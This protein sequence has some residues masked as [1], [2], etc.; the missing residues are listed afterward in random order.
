L[1]HVDDS[2]WSLFCVRT[3]EYGRPFSALAR[4]DAGQFDVVAPING[5]DSNGAVVVEIPQC[6]GSDTVVRT[7]VSVIDILRRP[8]IFEIAELLAPYGVMSGCI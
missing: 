2:R 4:G 5:G 8:G 7:G 1:V 6:P 3:T